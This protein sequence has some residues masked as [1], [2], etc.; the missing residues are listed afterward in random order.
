VQGF[1]EALQPFQDSLVGDDSHP[2]FAP[3]D[4]PNGSSIPKTQALFAAM[5]SE[6]TAAKTFNAAAYEN[7]T[8][9]QKDY[10][11]AAGENPDLLSH[12]SDPR[13]LGMQRAGLLAGLIE[14]GAV[15]EAHA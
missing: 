5:D 12:G 11:A 10:A 3:L 8:E 15:T 1:S 2:G 13:V 14:G 7:V 9:F 4:D 6:P